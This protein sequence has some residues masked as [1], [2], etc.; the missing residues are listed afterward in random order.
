M[1]GG[2]WEMGSWV[3][4]IK[5]GTYCDDYSVLYINDESLNSNAVTSIALHAS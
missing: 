4:G 3:I 1:E 2:G 5:D